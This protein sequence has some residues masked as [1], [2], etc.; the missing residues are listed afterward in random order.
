MGPR[1]GHI[2][3]RDFQNGLDVKC[4]NHCFWSNARCFFRI[5]TG[6]LDF[7]A[8]S[9]STS[10]RGSILRHMPILGGAQ[11]TICR[12]D[13]QCG[14][15]DYQPAKVCLS[16]EVNHLL[17]DD[18][19]SGLK[20]LG[21][22]IQKAWSLLGFSINFVSF[23]WMTWPSL[24]V[25]DSLISVIWT[26]FLSKSHASE[27]CE[28]WIGPQ[29]LFLANSCYKLSSPYPALQPAGWVGWKATGN[30]SVFGSPVLVCSG[31]GWGSTSL[32]ACKKPS[33]RPSW[34][35]EVAQLRYI[36]EAFWRKSWEFPWL[37]ITRPPCGK[38]GCCIFEK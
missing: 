3:L 1:W 17:Q 10:R 37:G 19:Q 11:A 27:I 25:F 29:V 9:W 23:A 26:S 18:M 32:A 35:A 6:T 34:A 24:A 2:G 20:W 36:P 4:E 8:V 16:F 30:G 38:R 12:F 15:S 5:G 21:R 22:E 13:K 28:C 14:G 31:E 7:F 33:V